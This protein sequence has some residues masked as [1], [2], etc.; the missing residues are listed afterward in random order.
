MTRRGA[1]RQAGRTAVRRLRLAAHLSGRTPTGA[2]VVAIDAARPKLGTTRART[3]LGALEHRA[4][5]APGREL[6]A[7]ARARAE[8]SAGQVPADLDVVVARCLSRADAA[9]A[10]RD[11]DAVA[12]WLHEA[13]HLTF[14]P[15]RHATD[16]QSPLLADPASFLAPLRASAAYR[17]ATEPSTAAAAPAARPARGRPTRIL[18]VS[19]GN[20][21][22]LG[23]ILGHYANHPNAEVR[24]MDLARL[25]DP[26]WEPVLYDLIRARLARFRG[27]PARP[28]P[29][30]LRAEL[31][32]ADVVL[33]EW[34]HRPAAWVTALAEVPAR[35]VVRLHS[36]EAT[37]PLP[38]LVDWGRVDDVVFVGEPTRR[39]VEAA[40]PGVTAAGRRHTIPNFADL[41]RFTPD[42]RPDAGHTLGL[43]GWN[44]PVKDPLWCLDLLERLRAEDPRWRLRLIGA[45]PATTAPANLA[46]YVR[47]RLDR[48]GDAVDVVGRTDDVPGALQGVG[49]IV[50]S[51]LRES[52]HLG[53]VEGAASAAVPVVRDWPHVHRWGGARD[54]YPAPWVVQTVEE[55]AG[56]VLSVAGHWETARHE[57]REWVLSHLDWAAV[58]PRYD[59]LLLAED[60]PA[61]KAPRRGA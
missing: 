17:A 30:G 19:Y 13:L 40:V 52:A 22:F 44:L 4:P 25:P 2:L 15:T 50:S 5:T 21:N 60:E 11:D 42:K 20:W 7:A 45:P 61:H 32:W 35:V 8:L 56:R 38:Q 57:A 3:L 10:R 27:Q 55:A 33:V 12:R 9:L 6:A 29:A 47:A 51:S 14:H 31:A 18:A 36:Y 49:W 24:T 58:R 41:R 39:L 28:L 46:A 23:G 54:L 48:L 43:V 16:Q 59:D 26:A 1:L 53:L 34:A 37:T